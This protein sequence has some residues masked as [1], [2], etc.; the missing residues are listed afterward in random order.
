VFHVKGGIYTDM[1]F[2]KLE[3]GEKPV[4]LGPFRTYDEAHIAWRDIASRTIDICTA[5][6]WIVETEDALQ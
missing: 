4:D 5:K 6:Y 1:S 2:T 3:P